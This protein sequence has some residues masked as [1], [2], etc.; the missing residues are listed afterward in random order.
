MAELVLNTG[1]EKGR[2]QRLPR[3]LRIDMTPMVDLGFLLITFFIFTTTISTPSVTSLIMPKEGDPSPLR[4]SNALTFLLGDRNKVYSYRG[5]WETA[6]A[7]NQI[8]TT[9]YNIYEGIGKIIRDQQ[10]DLA[11]DN[12]KDQLMVI[13]K[14]SPNSNYKNVI[15]ALDEATINDVK[16][17]AI[18]EPDAVEKEWMKHQ[19]SGN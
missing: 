9:D 10:S 6:Y 8:V 3:S 19:D 2:L 15:D 16:K 5:K 11:Q 17:Y 4:E 14:P 18:V 12:S 7:G 13:I 1:N